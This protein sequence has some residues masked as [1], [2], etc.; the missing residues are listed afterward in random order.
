MLAKEIPSLSKDQRERLY[1]SGDFTFEELQSLLKKNG[2]SQPEIVT[3]KLLGLYNKQNLSLER[4]IRLLKEKRAANSEANKL[5]GMLGMVPQT[6][7]ADKVLKYERGLQ[8][9]IYQ[10]L[11]M[12]KKLQGLF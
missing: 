12:L 9:S 10:N 6:D 7:N 8:K 11:I 5:L 4:E 2:Y 1:Y 3:E